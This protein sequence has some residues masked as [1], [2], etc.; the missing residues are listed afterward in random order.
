MTAPSWAGNRQET[1]RN[2][3][4]RWCTTPRC[5]RRPSPCRTS[6]GT[7]TEK[8]ALLVRALT[9]DAEGWGECVAMREPL[10]SPEYVDMAQDVVRRFLLPRLF[11]AG[12]L[13]AGQIAHVLEPIKGH[14]M[15]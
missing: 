11:G 4:E 15:A 13:T 7:E 12:E 3:P 1:C 2:R 10:Y 5:G 14:P 6:F 8:D 9:P